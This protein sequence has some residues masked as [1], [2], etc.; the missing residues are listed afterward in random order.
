MLNLVMSYQAELLNLLTNQLISHSAILIA[1]LTSTF[2][3]L[4]HFRPYSSQSRWRFVKVFFY[5]AFGGAL[6]GLVFYILYRLILYSQLWG[7]AITLDDNNMKSLY[8]YYLKVFEKAFEN[9]E[10]SGWMRVIPGVELEIA[11]GF[12]WFHKL[13]IFWRLFICWIFGSLISYL[14]YFVIK[15]ES[16]NDELKLQP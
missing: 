8:E 11:K 3:Y 10:Y 9:I 5:I 6:F 4:H 2:Y 14:M 15:H 12:K 1:L 13:P 16:H 7:V